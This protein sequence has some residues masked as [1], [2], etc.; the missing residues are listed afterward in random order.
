MEKI[1]GAYQKHYP[2]LN[3]DDLYFLSGQFEIMTDIIASKTQRCRAEVTNEI[4]YW[5]L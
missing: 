2:L 1:K 5:D 3:D 4:R